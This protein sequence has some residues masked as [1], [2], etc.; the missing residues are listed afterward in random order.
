M[1]TML[2]TGGTRGIGKAVCYHFKNDYKVVTVAR[3]KADINSDLSDIEQCKKLTTTITPDVFINN[4]GII[5]NDTKTMFD[6]N[7]HAACFLMNE[8]YNKMEEGGH[9]INISSDMSESSGYPDMYERKKWYALSKNNL[10]HMA[11]MLNNTHKRNIKITTLF[12]ER[13][14]T[15][16][17]TFEMT[18]AEWDKSNK[19]VYSKTPILP[20]EI[21]EQIEF[22]LN[23]PPH[24]NITE[25]KMYNQFKV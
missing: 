10:N 4:A 17:S 9:I 23:I 12:L 8:Y 16:M 15:D 3:S 19:D 21:S 1:K 6:L 22:I 13:V 20:I 5:S 14:N 25:M 7:A 24:Y 2:I 11:E 18:K